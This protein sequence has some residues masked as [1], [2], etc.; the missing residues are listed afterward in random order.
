MSNTKKKNVK[1]NSDI[2]KTCKCCSPNCIYFSKHLETNPDFEY[3]KDGVKRLFCPESSICMFDLHD[4]TKWEQCMNFKTYD[5]VK[6]KFKS[7]NLKKQNNDILKD[8]KI[9]NSNN[10]NIHNI[11][12]E[13]KLKEELKEELLQKYDNMQDV[14]NDESYMDLEDEEL[15]KYMETYIKKSDKCIND[16]FNIY[17]KMIDKELEKIDLLLKEYGESIID[18]SKQILKRQ[19]SDIND[20]CL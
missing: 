9:I 5:D 1:N 20:L 3:D 19:E 7:I 17:V 16:Y 14:F 13:E 8:N 15:E 2:K 4:I 12:L 11:D 10:E 6:W 18:N